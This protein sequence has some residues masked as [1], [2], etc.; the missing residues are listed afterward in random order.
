MATTVSHLRKVYFDLPGLGTVSKEADQMTGVTGGDFLTPYP[1]VRFRGKSKAARNVSGYWTAMDALAYNRQIKHTSSRWQPTIN[2][3]Y[4]RLVNEVNGERSQIGVLFAEWRESQGMIT[5]RALGLRNAYRSLR[6][7]DFRKFLKELSVSPKRKHRSKVRNAANEASG[8]WLEYWFGWSPFIGDIY[9][10]C[11]QLSEPLPSGI[12]VQGSAKDT[13]FSGFDTQPNGRT[14]FCLNTGV[15]RTGARFSLVNPNLYLASQMGLINPASVVWELIPFSFLVDWVA[16]IGS[17]L[18]SFS[19]FAGIRIDGPY[20]NSK[21]VYHSE[22]SGRP[23]LDRE[24]LDQVRFERKSG[25]LRPLPNL[26]VLQNLGQ[27]H[28]RAAT[29]VSLLVQ[30]LKT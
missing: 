27:S 29:A 23:D 16:D 15:F 10:A 24:V 13:L 7:G 22:R 30:V 19:D 14:D 1:Y 5:K 8:L 18:D 6:R 26:G 21:M 4:S 3:A 28:T 2:K 9:S 20:Q 11:L 17:F 12:R 25:L